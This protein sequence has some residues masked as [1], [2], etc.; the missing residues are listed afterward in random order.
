MEDDAEDDSAVELLID[1]AYAADDRFT[2]PVEDRATARV[3]C[4]HLDGLPLA[5]ELAV[6]QLVHL[7]VA[8]L[9]DRLDRRF[10]LLVGGRRRRRQRQQTLMDWSW[11]LFDADEQHLLAA[12]S[13]FT[14]SVGLDAIQDVCG[15]E[16]TGAVVPVLR[17][18]VAKSL[19]EARHGGS[20]RYR[21]LETVRMFAQQKLVDSGTAEQLRL[22]H[23]DWLI[24]W[25]NSVPFG[26][27]S[28]SMTW[29]R[30]YAEDCDSVMAA[31]DWSIDRNEWDDAALL[32]A[33][34]SG[35]WRDGF[36]CI[37]AIEACERLLSH[38][39]EPAIRCRLL[40]A[41]ADAAMAAGRHDLMTT[42]TTTAL[43]ECRALGDPTLHA[44][45][46]V[47]AGIPLLLPD[48][49][50]GLDLI[51]E[52][53][54]VADPPLVAS[55]L[56]EALAGEPGHALQLA[57]GVRRELER[58]SESP[59]RHSPRTRHRRDPRRRARP[60]SMTETVIAPTSP[61]TI[62]DAGRHHRHRGNRFG[63]LIGPV[64]HV[65]RWLGGPSTAVSRGN[66]ARTVVTVGAPDGRSTRPSH[67]GIASRTRSCRRWGDDTLR[68]RVGVLGRLRLLG[69]ARRDVG[70]RLGMAGWS[71]GDATC[72]DTRGDRRRGRPSDRRWRCG[73]VLRVALSCSGWTSAARGR[74]P[75]P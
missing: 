40:V 70:F 30:S 34:G 19:V 41:G 57:A 11:D 4:R 21:L 51:V 67:E 42:W 64:R 27:H 33:A 17:D 69:L 68:L 45:A 35:T 25:V 59:W 73:F 56:V 43:A 74:P 66:P 9:A 12:L 31:V 62:T 8:D 61:S 71:A 10:E 53:H 49:S 18:L 13:V 38:D 52:G 72:A 16:I 7:G 36:R 50:R 3:L 58:T 48:H 26:V 23:R 1:R 39:L 54:A 37:R 5:I 55:V 15:P 75:I 20:A 32:V 46:A 2:L 24:V 60:R 29:S 47:W 14:G 65:S 63:W 28:M 22:R 44:L 6:A